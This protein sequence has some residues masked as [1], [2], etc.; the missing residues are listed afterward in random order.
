MM[1]WAALSLV[2]L[3]AGCLPGQEDDPPTGQTESQAAEPA[4]ASSGGEAEGNA[5]DDAAPLGVGGPQID[6]ITL[7]PAPGSTPER[8]PMPGN[9]RPVPHVYVSLQDQGEG[10]PISV[11]FAIDGARDATPSDDPAIRLTPD[12]GLCNPQ[13]MTQYNFPE[14]DADRPVVTEADRARGL[15]AAN[16]PSVLAVVVTEKMIAQ[17]L[18]RTPEETR[19]Q[20]VCTRKLW[21][22]L[23]LTE[24]Q[25]SATGEVASGQ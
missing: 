14:A 21:E 13:S 23:V 10:R 22:Q 16:L 11:I 25:A 19:A 1:R 8:V 15:T 6:P 5:G 12:K 7:L 24:N 17:G 3:L 9:Q 2:A 18:A 4:Q 20:N